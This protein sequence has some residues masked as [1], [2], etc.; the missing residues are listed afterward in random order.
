MRYENLVN[1]NFELWGP[2]SFTFKLTDYIFSTNYSHFFYYGF[3]CSPR[4][5]APEIGQY[6]YL[7]A[8]P[9]R[10]THNIVSKT[11]VV[12]GCIA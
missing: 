3:V 7:L 1:A 8:K 10:R 4:F 2:N 6:T 9:H 5:V 11:V 12:I